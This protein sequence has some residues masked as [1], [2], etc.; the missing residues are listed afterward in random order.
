MLAY[1]NEPSVKTTILAELA[2]HRQADALVQGYGYWKDG[3]GCAV[4]CTIRSGNHAE[5]ETR[6]GIPQMLARLEDCIFEGLPVENARAW[7]ERFMGAIRPGADLSRVGWQF[8]HWLLTDNTVNPGID[9]PL[10]CDA[11]KQCANVIAL[12]SKG[13][14]AYSA[15][16]SAANAAGAADSAARAADRAADR[17]ASAAY[18]RMS[19]KLIEL[20]EAA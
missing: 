20:I 18:V 19:E 14:N 4:G 13:D 9:H 1:H 17:A 5:Y 16:Y 2:D 10:V 11:V 12:L 3:K 8:L 15:A 7:P 6:F